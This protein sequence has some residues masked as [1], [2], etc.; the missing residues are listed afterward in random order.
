MRNSKDKNSLISSITVKEIKKLIKE[1]TIDEG[2][3]PKVKAAAAAIGSGVE[4]AHIVDAK[5]S[6]AILFEIFT[7]EGISTEIIK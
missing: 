3:I 4:K 7:D 2:M 5:I 6:H 1:K